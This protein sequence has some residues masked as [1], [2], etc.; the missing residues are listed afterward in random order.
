MYQIRLEQFEGPLDLLLQLIEKEKL[1]ISRISL[2]QITDQFVAYL[3]LSKTIS[4]EE[5]ADFLVVA[6]RLLFL[7]SQT[8]F[9]S[10]EMEDEGSLLEAQLKM[11]KEYWDAAK[12]LESMFGE[13]RVIFFRERPAAEASFRPP[14]SVTPG[15][16][17]TVLQSVIQALEPLVMVP[18][19]LAISGVSLEDRITELKNLVLK[20]ASLSFRELIQSKD[21]A[22]RIVHFLAVLELVKQQILD[23]RQRDVFGEIHLERTVAAR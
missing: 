13:G 6:A 17:S 14:E 1:D 10:L 9:P 12:I 7:K 2:S 11:Y 15:K 20:R 19:K 8:L 4:L 3:E 23:V 21:K 18:E 16:L 5:M 22:E